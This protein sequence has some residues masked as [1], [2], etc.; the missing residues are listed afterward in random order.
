ML[1]LAS[2][3]N[4]NGHIVRGL[5][6]RA[7]DLDLIRIQDAGLSGVDDP[8]LLEWAAQEERILLTH[9]V[10]TMAG[11]AYE[12]VEA[13]LK[14]P[15]LVEVKLYA[16]LRQIIDDILLLAL[17]SLESEWEGRVAFIPFT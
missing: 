3:E 17:Y 9:D 8:S 6:R 2:D 10:N 15:G 13:G 7:P 11:F 1:S 16:P 5:L 14:M 12:R 4:F